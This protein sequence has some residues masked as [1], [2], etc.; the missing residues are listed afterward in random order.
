MLRIGVLIEKIEGLRF[1]GGDLCHCSANGVG[2]AEL[3]FVCAPIGAVLCML[4]GSLLTLGYHG[5]TSLLVLDITCTILYELAY[6]WVVNFSTTVWQGPSPADSMNHTRSLIAIYRTS[7]YC[8]L[9]WFS[10]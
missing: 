5:I 3:S 6:S 1:Y 7:I 10:G 2:T 9:A 4:R 8:K